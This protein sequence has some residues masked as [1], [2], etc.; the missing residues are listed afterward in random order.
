MGIERRRVEE[1][2]ADLVSDPKAAGEARALTRATLK[3]WKLPTLLDDVVLT[4]S[5]LVGNAV[6]HGSPPIALGLRRRR[7]SLL[8]EVHDEAP[9]VLHERQ[10]PTEEAESGRGLQIV[11]SL[12]GD[13]GVR[14]ITGDGKV[15]WAQFPLDESSR[16]ERPPATALQDGQ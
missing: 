1:V 8:V 11:E 13:A 16:G 2:H 5:E 7:E 12:A 3:R 4:V 9:V 10:Q 15:T 14:D 6:R